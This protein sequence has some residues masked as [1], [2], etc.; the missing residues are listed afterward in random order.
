LQPGDLIYILILNILHNIPSDTGILSFSGYNLIIALEKWM[1]HF[2]SVKTS[3][4]SRIISK[5]M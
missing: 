5:T 2:L 1:C 3:E 4:K